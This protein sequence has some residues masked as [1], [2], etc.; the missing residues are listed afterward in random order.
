M[1]IALAARQTPPI[2]AD[3]MMI[4]VKGGSGAHAKIIA[5]SYV[6]PVLLPHIMSWMDSAFANVVSDM[7]NGF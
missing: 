2:I 5:G 3:N 4:M 7:V 1:V 6:H